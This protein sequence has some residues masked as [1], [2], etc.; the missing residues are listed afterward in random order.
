MKRKLV[1][2]FQILKNQGKKIHFLYFVF[3]RLFFSRKNR[4]KYFANAN[5]L[6][7][8]NKFDDALQNF[9]Y[10]IFMS[11]KTSDYDFA[12][13]CLICG[14]GRFNDAMD[15]LTEANRI[16][17]KNK[18]LLGVKNTK[19]RLLMPIWVGAIG[20]IAQ[21]QYV[22]KL[23]LL[24]KINTKKIILIIPENFPIA[25]KFLL[26]L[27]EKYITI[28]QDTEIFQKSLNLR[29]ATEFNFYAPQNFDGS[30]EY[31]WKLASKVND[32]WK[33]ENRPKLIEFPDDKSDRGREILE[34]AIGTKFNW[35]VTLHVREISSKN[36]HSDLH[37]SLNADITNYMSSIEEITSRGGVVVR[38]GDSTMTPLPK[39]K[40]VF[41]YAH[42]NEKFDWLDIYFLSKC[43]FFLGTSSGP[44]YV[45]AIFDIPSVLTNWWPYFQLPWSEKSIFIPKLLRSVDPDRYLTLKEALQEPFGYCNSKYYLKK[46]YDIEI[47]QNDPEDIKNAVLEMLNILLYENYSSKEN[48]ELQETVKQIYLNSGAFGSGLVSSSFIQK[49]LNI[50]I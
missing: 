22:I 16:R 42:S 6:L 35:F 17:K 21:L 10:H 36:H 29:L 37:D 12:A 31:Y 4:N 39:M 24:E 49:Y 44:A 25:N 46:N 40:N 3:K 11:N 26:S 47:L 7:N 28:I 27:L 50:F 34:R 23:N 5:D 14:M 19:I 1:Q 48:L 43:K 30:T 32:R 38:I 41:D 15:F 8:I 9:H 20:H 33:S 18:K 2:N 45:P 13:A